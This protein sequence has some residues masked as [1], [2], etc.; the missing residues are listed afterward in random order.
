M[1]YGMSPLQS[2]YRPKAWNILQM[3]SRYKK[4][5]RLNTSYVIKLCLNDTVM[6]AL[7][8]KT[9]VFSHEEYVLPMLAFFGRNLLIMVKVNIV[10]NIHIYC[11]AA[12]VCKILAS[13]QRQQSPPCCTSKLTR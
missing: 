8:N 6:I 1:I 3:K 7:W 9:P 10:I 4:K 13:I 5:A 12:N 11:D 2:K